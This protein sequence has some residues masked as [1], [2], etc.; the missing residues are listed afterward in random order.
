MAPT[1]LLNREQK[2]C[3]L[4]HKHRKIMDFYHLCFQKLQQPLELLKTQVILNLN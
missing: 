4:H 3:P 1:E 2:F